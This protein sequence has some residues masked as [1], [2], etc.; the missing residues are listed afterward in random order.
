MNL[1]IDIGRVLI[2]PGGCGGN[3][4]TSFIEG[5]LEEALQTPPM[6][7]AFEAV[8]RLVEVFERRVWLIS[9]CFPRVQD[10]TRRWLDHHG[11][12]DKTGLRRDRLIF[13]LE[14]S[15]KA[16][17]CE[18]LGIEYFIDDRLDVLEAMR[19]RVPHLFLFGEQRRPVPE[20]DW[21]VKV[22][23]WEVA[24]SAVLERKEKGSAK[25]S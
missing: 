12:Y 6:A 25:R 22:P 8:T 21:L 9:K 7:G 11:F 4:D 3:E 5:T 10:R 17:H 15:Q 13:C 20:L 23:N 24:L 2:A 19:G 18:R 1:G 14:R 16:G